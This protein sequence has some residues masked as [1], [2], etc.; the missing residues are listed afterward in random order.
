[1]SVAN[2]QEALHY[3]IKVYD[4]NFGRNYDKTH[5]KE[6]NHYI[7]KHH[8]KIIRKLVKVFRRG[9]LKILD[10]GCGTGDLSLKFCKIT[11]DSIIFNLDLSRV[12]LKNLKKKLAPEEIKRNIFICQDAYEYLK[13]TKENFDIIAT[14]GTLHH[15]FDYLEVVNLSCQKLKDNGFLYIACEAKRHTNYFQ[16]SIHLMDDAV[17]M[18]KYRKLTFLKFIIY[19]VYSFTHFLQPITKCF[20]KKII[21]TNYNPEE[22]QKSEIIK[23]MNMKE[24]FKILKNNNMKVLNY[25]DSPVFKNEIFYKI[26]LMFGINDYFQLIAKKVG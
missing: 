11:K 3:N 17:Y 14:S 7:Q 15:L 1:M 10:I 20:R 9:S 21:T 4:G 8:L 25:E 19:F 24:I 16:K 2:K 22:Q 6:E 18:Y 13:N 12:M 23:K 5:P 26:T